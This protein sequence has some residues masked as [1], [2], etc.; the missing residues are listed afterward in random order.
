M[1]PLWTSTLLAALLHP[2]HGS[3]ALHLN[4]PRSASPLSNLLAPRAANGTSGLA[5]DGAGYDV[6]ITLGGQ[7][8]KAQIDTGR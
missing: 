4:L 3:F 7:S 2:I 8:F 6:D 5:F 1:H